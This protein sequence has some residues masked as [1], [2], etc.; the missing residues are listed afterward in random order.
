MS[1]EHRRSARVAS[2]VALIAAVHAS[3]RSSF[4]T[5]PRMGFEPAT[6]EREHRR[7]AA[8]ARSSNASSVPGAIEPKSTRPSTTSR[9]ASEAEVIAAGKRR[10]SS[11][12]ISMDGA[13]GGGEGLG[14]RPSKRVAVRVR[15]TRED[16]VIIVAHSS[17]R[18][19]RR[20][21]EWGLPR[22]MS[23][24]PASSGPGR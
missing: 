18:L 15:T 16:D 4:A 10:S 7:S 24:R 14:R 2:V 17:H 8:A 12:R 13:V 9:S 23:D 1:R 19:N 3:A 21:R 22:T 11:L 6:S 20:G 5:S